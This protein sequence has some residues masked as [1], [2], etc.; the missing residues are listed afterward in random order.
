VSERA[1]VDREKLTGI[2]VE[3]LTSILEKQRQDY[4]MLLRAIAMD[5]TKEIRGE[6]MRFVDAMHHATSVNVN[7]GSLHSPNLAM[8]ALN[9]A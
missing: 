1:D 7:C 2:A 3:N 9:T 4:E 5:L 6:H 8:I